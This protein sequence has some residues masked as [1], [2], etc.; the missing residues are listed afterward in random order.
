MPYQRG[1]KIKGWTVEKVYN[2][3]TFTFYEVALK[4]V[5]GRTTCYSWVQFNKE[6]NSV[7]KAHCDFK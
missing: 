7:R 5:K 3:P 1:E 4:K 2:H 6:D